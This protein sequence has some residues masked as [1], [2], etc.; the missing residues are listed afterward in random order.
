MGKRSL[1]NE[2][3][4]T[5]RI[6]RHCYYRAA[7][8]K[9]TEWTS[10]MVKLTHDSLLLTYSHEILLILLIKW[11]ETESLTLLSAYPFSAFLLPFCN[12]HS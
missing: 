8:K 3:S 4:R 1:K 7:E 6:I 12:N 9:I 2:S 5:E 10:I 11:T